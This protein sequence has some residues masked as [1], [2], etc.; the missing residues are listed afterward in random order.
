VWRA[1][2][3][4][5]GTSVP[6]DNNTIVGKW[7]LTELDN[8]RLRLSLFE[9]DNH[10]ASVDMTPENMSE[11]VELLDSAVRAKL[12]P[13]EKRIQLYVKRWEELHG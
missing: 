11:L 10:I 13:K 6:T 2:V 1:T 3:D 5:K 12:H 7:R 4:R 9:K 8:G